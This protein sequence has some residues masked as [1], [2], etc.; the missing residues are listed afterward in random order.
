MSIPPASSYVPHAARR[1]AFQAPAS[2]LLDTVTHAADRDQISPEAYLA[3]EGSASG[4]RPLKDPG[5]LREGESLLPLKMG[6]LRAAL[7]EIAKGDP[8]LL[9]QPPVIYTG[10]DLKVHL[11]FVNY[12][13]FAIAPHGGILWRAV[14][15]A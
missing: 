13:G 8:W 11:D 5:A 15:P 9:T 7:Q 3:A 4:V 12:A 1:V 10:S 2:Q 6:A 14:N